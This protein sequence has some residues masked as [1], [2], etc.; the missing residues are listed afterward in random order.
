MELS[1]YSKH[2]FFLDFSSNLKGDILRY[3]AFF[4]YSDLSFQMFNRKLFFNPFAGL[5]L[6]SLL[7]NQAQAASFIQINSFNYSE[8]IAIDAVLND[9]K[10]DFKGGETILSLSQVEV[11]FKYRDWQFSAFQRI[12][13]LLEFSKDTAEFVYTTQNKLPLDENREYQL[14]LESQ[15]FTANGLKVAFSDRWQDINWQVGLSYLQG[16]KLTDGSL[17]GVAT[18]LNDNDYDFNFA[19]DYYYDDDVLFDRSNVQAPDGQGFALD[20]SVKGQF[21][22]QWSYK[23]QLKDALAYIYWQDAPRTVADGTSDT[24]TYDEDGY[25]EFNPVASGA[26]SYEDFTQRIPLKV[27]LQTTYQVDNNNSFSFGYRNLAI[28]DFYHAAYQYQTSA[29]RYTIGYYL[30]AQAWNL[31][32]QRSWLKL[33]LLSDNFDYQKARTLGINLG[34]SYRF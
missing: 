8:P 7:I 16:F 6:S 15:S 34:L 13:Y 30:N 17:N 19:V 22:Q 4:I 10:G 26:E 28:K 14:S 11:G 18:K 31:S 21:N 5:C 2:Y 23:A 32:Y 27:N 9:W 24:K 25:V 33:Q 1:N 29:A 3:I 12:D 20:L